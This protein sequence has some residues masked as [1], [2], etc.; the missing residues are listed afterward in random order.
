MLSF[1]L[2]KLPIS[3]FIFW[4]YE[5]PIGLF[6]YFGKVNKGFLR[7]VSLPILI[8]TFFKPWKNE[9][10]QGLVGFS[11]AM[12]M[13][14]KSLVIIADI[15]LFIMLLFLE[16]SVIVLFFIWPIYV[17]LLLMFVV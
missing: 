9:Y 10:R 2:V 1:L 17:V 8:K 4:F 5:A 16:L 11:M 14:I 15:F 6:L 12:G 3:F 7:L 13:T